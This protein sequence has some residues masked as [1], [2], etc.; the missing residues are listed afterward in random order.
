MKSIRYCTRQGF[1]LI[2][3]L[4]VIAI[5]GVLASVVLASVS[6]AR[7]K[8]KATKMVSELQQMEKAIISLTIDT[9]TLTLWRENNFNGASLGQNPT[10]QS[11]IDSGG[12]DK[13]FTQAPTPPEGTEPYKYDNDGDGSQDCNNAA[14][15]VNIIVQNAA[16]SGQLQGYVDQ[17]IDG[18]DG[19]SCGKVR[20]ASNG[21]GLFLYKIALKDNNF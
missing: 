2:E 20:R 13:Y 1:T 16:I 12:L 11:L 3:L 15:G 18:G 19:N 21:G 6:T 10:L 14:A 5:I 4:V 8:A 17:M 9:N 7:E